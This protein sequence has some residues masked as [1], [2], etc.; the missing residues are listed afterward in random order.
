MEEVVE[1]NLRIDKMQRRVYKDGV[2]VEMTGKEFDLLKLLVEN[3]G[4]VL[5]K[6]S[7]FR[8]VWGSDSF[9]EPQTL[10]VHI[11]WLREKIE[12]NP[13]EPRRI[14]TVWGVGYRFE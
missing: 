3:K 4:K 6:E 5:K 14:Q 7:I 10:T 13:R 2:F 8:Q 12:E 9:S 11:K 1:G